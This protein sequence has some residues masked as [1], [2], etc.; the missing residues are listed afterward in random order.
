MKKSTICLF[1]ILTVCCFLSACQEQYSGKKQF[2]AIKGILDLSEW[3]FGRDGP[4]KLDGEWEYYEG[5][6]LTPDSFRMKPGPEKTA[7]RGVVGKNPPRKGKR[8]IQINHQ[9]QGPG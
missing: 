1:F 6:L 9:I 8:H 2:E 4:I 3:D 5:Q 7:F